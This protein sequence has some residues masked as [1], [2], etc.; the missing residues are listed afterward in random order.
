MR[1]G[2][3]AEAVGTT[4][5]TIRYYEEIGLLHGAG[6]RASGQ[7]R[8]YTEQD[9]ERLRHALRLKELL[10]LSL[11]ELREL[12]EAQD[13]RAALRD[14]WHHSDPGPARRAQIL[15]ESTR[16]LDRQL[17][18]VRRRRE[19]I[20]ALEAELAERRARVGALLTELRQP[21]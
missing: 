10:G 7:H 1:I 2:E 8:T 11:D 15:Q 4:S 13:A 16:H 19:E 21:A 5:R 6:E 12:L 18:L 3:V 14:E 20:D 9:V 17:E